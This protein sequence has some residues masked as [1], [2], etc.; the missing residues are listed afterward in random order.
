MEHS[1]DDGRYS[2]HFPDPISRPSSTST[3]NSALHHSASLPQ[4]PGLSALASLATS[5]VPQMSN[6]KVNTSNTETM[7]NIQAG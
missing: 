2:M 7:E 4:L 5:N 3:V 1:T 6:R